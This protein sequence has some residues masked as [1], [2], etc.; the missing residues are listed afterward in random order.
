MTNWT[1]EYPAD[2]TGDVVSNTGNKVIIS[3]GTY[4]GIL[5]IALAVAVVVFIVKKA[6]R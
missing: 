6:R 1:A 4:A 2:I 5:A 3:I